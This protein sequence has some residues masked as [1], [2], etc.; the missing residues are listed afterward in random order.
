M[1][2]GLVVY[3]AVTTAIL[4]RTQPYQGRAAGVTTPA[5]TIHGCIIPT[6][7]FLHLSTLTLRLP[8]LSQATEPDS[9]EKCKHNIMLLA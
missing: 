5:A 9:Y 7:H 8:L 1:N 3:V 6:V 4:P 2:Y